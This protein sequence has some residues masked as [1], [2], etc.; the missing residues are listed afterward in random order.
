MGPLFLRL[1]QSSQSRRRR[2][3]LTIRVRRPFVVLRPRHR[4][5]RLTKRSAN[6]DKTPVL[7]D[8]ES[9]NHHHHRRRHRHH[10]YQEKHARAIDVVICLVCVPTREGSIG[11]A[12][13]CSTCTVSARCSEFRTRQREAAGSVR[14]KHRRQTGRSGPWP[15]VRGRRVFPDLECRQQP[16]STALERPN[17]RSLCGRL[18]RAGDWAPQL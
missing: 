1:M 15:A 6:E 18:H 17:P 16:K 10:R 5:T 3:D 11:L 7:M 8:P 13:I 14:G 12:R 2:E 9:L 4:G